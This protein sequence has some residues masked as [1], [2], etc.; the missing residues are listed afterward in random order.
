MYKQKTEEFAKRDKGSLSSPLNHEATLSNIRSTHM[1]VIQ[2]AP[3][4]CLVAS[5]VPF[6]FFRFTLL[7]NHMSCQRCTQ[8]AVMI[9]LFLQ[10]LSPFDG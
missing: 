6:R 9:D 5:Y 4:L 10:S 7:A 2:T 3:D 1:L 8:S